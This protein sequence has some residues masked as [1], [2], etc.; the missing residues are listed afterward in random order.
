MLNLQPHG[1]ILL[2]YDR[3]HF[4]AQDK[5]L[6]KK[7]LPFC[8]GIKLGL[9]AMNTPW[10]NRWG[11]LS[12]VAIKVLEW[13]KKHFPDHIIMWDGKFLDIKNTMAGA[14]CGAAAFYVWGF[15]IHASALEKGIRAAVAHRG[16]SLVIGVTAL[17]SYTDTEC[18]ELFGRQP[19][20]QVGLFAALLK[21]YGAQA[22]VCSPKHLE[23]VQKR[24]GNSLIRVTP[25]IRS[26]EDPPDDQNQTMS[27]PDAVKAGADYI[28]VGRPIM[29]AE[30]PI[31]AACRMVDSIT[32]AQ[33]NISMI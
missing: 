33:A 7:V 28:V 27:A 8:G 19:K 17:T 24:A 9:E 13:M 25:G 20:A 11:S 4:D 26:K 6:L 5:R 30:A 12:S 21:E 23:M 15:T 2:A 29:K 32:A 10:W 3:P 16:N 31:N 1:R 14:A 18:K 22:I